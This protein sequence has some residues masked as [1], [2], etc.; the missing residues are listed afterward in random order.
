MIKNFKKKIVTF[1]LVSIMTLGLSVSALAASQSLNGGGATW[2]GG[3]N[4][5]D[6]VYS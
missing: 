6:I 2:K 1:G 4:S 3:E 5:S